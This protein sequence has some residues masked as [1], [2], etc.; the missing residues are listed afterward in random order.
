LAANKIRIEFP[1]LELCGDYLIKLMYKSM[2][3]SDGMLCRFSFNTA[4]I[5][6]DLKLVFHKYNIDP[7]KIQKNFSDKFFIVTNF[8]KCIQCQISCMHEKRNAQCLD[9]RYKIKQDIEHWKAIYSYL[10][11]YKYQKLKSQFQNKFT[12]ISEKQEMVSKIIRKIG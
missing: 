1:R 6:L 7:D 2:I 9:C 8:S 10:R 3:L 5:G 12:G 4:M 11:E